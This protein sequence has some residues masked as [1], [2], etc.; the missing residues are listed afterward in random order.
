MALTKARYSMI[1]GDPVNV[2]DFI[3][4]G[5]DTTTTDCTTFIQAAIDAASASG[6][7]VVVFG[8]KTYRIDST[9]QIKAHNTKIEGRS[10]V[11]DY[12]GSSVAV[13]FVP[14][15]GTTYPVSCSISELSVL[16]RAASSGTGFRIRSSYSTF[17]RLDVVLYSAATAARGIMLVGDETNGTGPYYNTFIR[18]TVQS[19]S[20]GLDHIGISF[21]AAAPVYRSPNANTFIG[22]RVG[23]CL[24]GIVIKGNGNSFYNPTI[25]NAAL[26]G[27]AITFQADTSVNCA[28]NNVFGAYIENASVGVSFTANAS[29][30]SVYSDFMT[31]VSTPYSD[32]G[33]D[34]ILVGANTP[35][36]LPNGVK[37]AGTASSDAEV[38]DDYEEGTWTPVIAGSSIAGTYEI[39]TAYADYVKIGKSVTVNVFV[40]MAGSLSGG[41][42]GNLEITGLP[43]AKAL[44][45]IAQG[46]V[47]TR[48][49]DLTAGAISLSCGFGT[50]SSVSKVVL[51]E[52]IDNA[53]SVLVPISA[54]AAND[55]IQ[56]T[57]TYTSTT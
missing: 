37:L 13:D 50:T 4:S 9:V 22:G 27:D 54:I 40:L 35:A 51:E 42:S 5:T 19:Q 24:Q 10:A 38:L 43:F 2:D 20:L 34:N 6:G 46:S 31:G 12:Y 56:A 44:N 47:V 53:T 29:Y 36:V 26:T 1:S 16:V 55:A 17:D 45:S 39:A 57:I 23:Q 7:R 33:T 18:C 52:V 32:L 30:N 49:I 11:L 14:I 48:G 25:E 21:V 3:P 41:G 28:N 8:A 15:G